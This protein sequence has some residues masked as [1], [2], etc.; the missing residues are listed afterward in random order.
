MDTL[1][2]NIHEVFGIEKEECRIVASLFKRQILTKNEFFLE[3]NED[4]DQLSIIE[5]GIL[6]MFAQFQ[7]KEVTQWIGTPGYFITDYSAFLSQSKSRWNIQALTDC[8]IYTISYEDYVVLNK[9]V[10]KWNELE[11]KFIVKCAIF[12]ENRILS[13][14]SLSS[15]ERYDLL[16]DQQR[17]LFNQ[18]PLQYLASMLGMTPETF[19]RIRRK[20]TS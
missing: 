10:P 1:E 19:S 20:K 16:F 4:C 18:V 12:M 13:L 5:S 11:K 7:G 17:D 9:I 6:R 8:S 2:N 3:A 15:E 14:I